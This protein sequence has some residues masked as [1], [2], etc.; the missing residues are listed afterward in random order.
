MD[1]RER[2]RLH[3]A[4]GDPHRLDMV[5]HLLLSDL[6]FKE[7][8][9]SVG[10]AGNAAAHHLT[11]LDSV[12]LITRRTSEGDHRRRYVTLRPG[13]LEEMIGAPASRPA[14]VLFVCTHNSARSQFAAAL[15]GRRTGRPAESAG[16]TPAAAVHPAAV[17]AAEAYGLDLSTATPKGYDAV[18]TPPDLVVSVCDLAREA[19]LP[20]SV[21]SIHWSVPDPVQAG[22]SEAFRAAFAD[23]ATRIDQLAARTAA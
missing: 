11:V 3:A 19:G 21:P 6:T 14:V 13:R 15:W 10:L 9:D 1:V 12:G 22:T 8:A 4:L 20:F 23:V 5:E 18:A 7:L 2:A 16:T 17:L